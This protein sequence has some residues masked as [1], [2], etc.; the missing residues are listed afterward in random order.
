M[1]IAARYT[2]ISPDFLVWKVCGN[3]NFRRVLG[4]LNETF[5][6]LQNYQTGK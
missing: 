3:D 2:E 4:K 6:F 1:T 5:A